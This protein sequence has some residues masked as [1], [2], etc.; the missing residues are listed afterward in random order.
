M[1]YGLNGLVEFVICDESQTIFKMDL[2]QF[3]NRQLWQ[4]IIFNHQS[5]IKKELS[6][7]TSDSKQNLHIRVGTLENYLRITNLDTKQS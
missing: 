3:L 7:L 2:K 4:K 1:E 6:D 5:Y